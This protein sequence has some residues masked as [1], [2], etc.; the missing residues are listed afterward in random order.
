MNNLGA[1]LWIEFRKAARSRV[2]LLTALGFLIAPLACAFLMFIY[3]NPD[4]AR[5]MGLVS[6]K[7][8][9]MG[10]S[11]DWPFFLSMLAQA[12]AVGG[13]LLFI[14]VISWVFGR[15]FTDGTVKDWLAVPVER[16][17]ILL[18]KFILSAGWSLGLS[19]MV[20]VVGIALGSIVGLAKWSP[21]AFVSGSVTILVSALLVAAVSTPFALV[22][23]IGRGYLLPVGIA[24]LVTALSQVVAL[25]GYGEFFPWAIPGMYAKVAG[26]QS[27]FSAASVWVVVLTCV[28]GIEG[29]HTWWMF[30]DQNK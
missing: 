2:P 9:L 11:A 23:S 24:I 10:G 22:A 3:K 7:A 19:L 30:T 16:G 28:M 1:M 21:E 18:A 8:N 5:S 27:A 12:I 6:A 15:E 25:V 14:L 20:Y 4:L 29:T 26:A 17:V 13:L